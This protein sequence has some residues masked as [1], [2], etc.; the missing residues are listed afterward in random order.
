MGDSKSWSS[1]TS[2]GLEISE[3][4]SRLDFMSCQQVKDISF[5]VRPN[6]R[7]YKEGRFERPT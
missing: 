5:R 7:S 3:K 6:L 2:N 1:L 4:T